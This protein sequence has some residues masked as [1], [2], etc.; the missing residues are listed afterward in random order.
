MSPLGWCQD[1]QGNQQWLRADAA[2]ALTRMNEAFRTEF[3]ENIAVD[4]SY[5]SY[6][7]QV[8][9]RD[10][11]GTLA[12]Q[13]GTSNHGTGPAIDTWEWQAYA[14]GSARYDWLVANAP[15]YGWA[16][17]DWARQG[18]SNSEHWNFEYVG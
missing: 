18:G 2:D 11:Y 6:D 3:S 13:P 16:A 8:Q 7:D 12:A 10:Y 4:L 15:S 14:F 5:R 1:S 9:M 17:P